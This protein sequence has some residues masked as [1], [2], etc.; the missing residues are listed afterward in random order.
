MEYLVLLY[1]MQSFSVHSL[2]VYFILSL[3]TFYSF[4]FSTYHCVASFLIRFICFVLFYTVL[5]MK[6]TGYIYGLIKVWYSLMLCPFRRSVRA[7]EY[8]N[9]LHIPHEL[10]VI[11]SY[12]TLYNLNASRIN[13]IAALYNLLFS[14]YSVVMTSLK[15]C[16]C[17]QWRYFIDFLK[18]LV[19]G[20]K[21]FHL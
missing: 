14:T 19:S 20:N 17:L 11:N 10:H 7:L 2:F 16:F 18:Y 13:I 4:G 6:D 5:L 21:N 8:L 15:F 1:L 9:C 3:F 12:L